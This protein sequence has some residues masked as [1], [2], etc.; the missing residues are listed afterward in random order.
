M[1]EMQ[2][3]F[4]GPQE[5]FTPNDSAVQVGSEILMHSKK[6]NLM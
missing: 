6:E 1:Q 4:L 2:Y 3:A 5:L